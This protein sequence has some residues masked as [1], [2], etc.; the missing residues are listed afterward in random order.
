MNNHPLNRLAEKAGQDHELI[1]AAIA[2]Y[3]DA[4]NATWEQ[5]A[6]NLHL[7]GDQLSHLALCR[8]PSGPNKHADAAKI[9]A[10]TGIDQQALLL[11]LNAYAP[12]SVEE[13]Q[14]M[15]IR[16]GITGRLRN[17]MSKNIA[18][19]ALAALGVLL[20]A[21]MVFAR[22][23]RPQATLVV[24][25][26][27]ATLLQ[28]RNVVFGLRST[29]QVNV[30]A[31]DAIGI[32]EGD[33]VSMGEDAVAQ[34]V[35]DD[36]ST[37]D[38]YDGADVT[39]A[40]LELGKGYQVEFEVLAGRTYHRVKHILGIDDIFKVSTPSSTASVR[41]TMFTVEA[42]SADASYFACDEGTVAVTM[43]DQ[44]V[45][46]NPG[47]ETVAAVGQPLE[48]KPQAEAT[49]MGLTIVSPLSPPAAGSSVVVSGY[50]AVGSSV[51][52][53]GNTVVVDGDGY[54]E[55]QVTAGEDP[56]VIISTDPSGESVTAEI[57]TK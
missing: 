17:I 45:V 30:G 15:Q 55:I 49:T 40:E 56:I 28:S 26:G 32:R 42:L 2:R 29:N 50:T 54:F 24:S 9:A 46:L 23:E 14:Q 6:S 38:L 18:K 37:V 16:E 34:L 48:A 35:L 20:V 22:P 39:V 51:T 11:F 8:I 21:G 3:I 10:Y 36:G 33:R 4:T 47:E 27:Q 43:G 57:S 7:S 53:D 25:E 31:G 19:W 41:G 1:A 12:P 5:A 13:L 52:I 44:E